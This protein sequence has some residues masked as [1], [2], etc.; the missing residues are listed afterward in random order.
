MKKIL[1]GILSTMLLLTI[2]CKEKVAEEAA[3]VESAPDV[4]AIKEAVEEATPAETV[5]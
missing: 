2:A 3:A 1:I 4:E 5:E